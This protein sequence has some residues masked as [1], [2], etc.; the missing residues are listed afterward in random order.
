MTASK[1]CLIGEALIRRPDN[2]QFTETQI[3]WSPWFHWAV[4]ANDTVYEVTGDFRMTVVDYNSTEKEFRNSRKIFYQI[5]LNDTSISSSED[6]KSFITSWVYRHP[7]GM[8]SLIGSNCQ[9]FA[10]DFA[11]HFFGVVLET[12]INKYQ[13]LGLF[14]FQSFT[15]VLYVA[16]ILAMIFF[17]LVLCT[18]M[19]R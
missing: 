5:N 16:A 18:Y 12:Q 3:Y 6:V 10:K 2:K 11:R 15:Y 19:V 14:F 7:T 9:D 1:V 17:H 13:A 4:F 8:Y